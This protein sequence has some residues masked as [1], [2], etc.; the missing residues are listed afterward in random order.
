MLEFTRREV[1]I[2]AAI[3]AAMAAAGGCV[4][5]QQPAQEPQAKDVD[6]WHKSVCRY[7][8]VGCGVLVGTRGGKVTAVKGD[9]ESSVNA[10]TLCVKAFFLTRIFAAPDRLKRP[11]LRKNDTFTEVSW[12]E[13]LT[14]M[15][16]RLQET[17]SVHGVD[18][19]AFYGSGQYSTEEGYLVNKLFK[20]AIGTNNIEGQPRT[21]MASAVA[22]F[23]TT[24]GRDMVM[25]TYED[26]ELADVFFIIGSNAAEAH[27]VIFARVTERKRTAPDVKVIVVDPRRTRTFDIADQGFQI[28]PN[29]DLVLLNAM[30]H[31]IIREGLHDPDFIGRHVNFVQTVEGANEPRSWEEYVAFLSEYTPKHAEVACGIPAEE[32][33]LAAKTF[34]MKDKNTVSM[35]S[36]GLNQRIRGTWANNLVHNLHLI[37]GKI[38]KPGSTPLSLTGQPNSNGTVRETGALSHMLPGHRLVANEKH[39]Q[40]V[41]E[42][43]G[44][45]PEKIRATP[46][47]HTMEMFEAARDGRVKWLWVACTNPGHTLPNLNRYRPGMEKTFMVVSEMY[48]PTRTSELADLVLPAATIYE[49]P[50]MFTNTERRTQHMAKAVE[51]PGEA[52]TELWVINELAKMLGHGELFVNNQTYEDVWAEWQ[53]MAAGTGVDVAAYSDYVAARGLQWPV[54]DGRETKRRYVYPDDP[55]VTADEKIRFYGTPDGRARVFLR[56]AAPPAETPDREYPFWFTNGR[57]LE[58]WHSRTMTGKA[59]ELDKI[60]TDLVEIHPEDAANLGIKDGD[61]IEITSRRGSITRKASIGRRGEPRKGL[62]YTCMHEM[63]AKELVNLL[64]VDQVDPISRQPEFKIAAVKIAKKV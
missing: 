17:I 23:V 7:C 13:A 28:V 37:T 29:S 11:L 49:K 9:A 3:T 59:T 21:C 25:G 56:P 44:I 5:P 55:F 64:T 57:T 30:A 1:L 22:G 18:A 12:D 61:L 53:R 46:G 43:W 60:P 4:P 27:P 45:P 51:P 40:E 58:H 31:V 36:M 16:D 41:A 19:I 34:A 54:V 20:G 48:H 24:Y 52:K 35:W 8:G 42:I 47:M 10:G 50:S 2:A 39:R 15:T 6:A 26:I 32:V 38:C 14:V 62:V 63:A 33:E